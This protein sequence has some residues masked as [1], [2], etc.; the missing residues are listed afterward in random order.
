MGSVP[1]MTWLPRPTTAISPSTSKLRALLAVDQRSL[2]EE[3]RALVSKHAALEH[4]RIIRAEG[5]G[6]WLEFRSVTA[7]AKTG[8]ALL[9]ELG[10][11]QPGKGD[12]RISIRVVIG[13]GDVATEMTNR[14]VSC[15]HS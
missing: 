10:V 1:K 8:V 5:D 9:E 11:A 13:L 14:S 3:H 2:L 12:S 6:Y 7:A 15:C 4:G